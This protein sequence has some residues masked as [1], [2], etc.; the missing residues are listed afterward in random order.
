LCF[1]DNKSTL[2]KNGKEKEEE[3]EE[4]RERKKKEEE[5]KIRN[6]EQG[7]SLNPKA[8]AREVLEGTETRAHS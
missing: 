3:E 5:K 7:S 8:E 1:F 2:Q 6:C 4:G